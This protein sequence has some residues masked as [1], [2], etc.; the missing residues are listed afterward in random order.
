MI[1][2]TTKTIVNLAATLVSISF[3]LIETDLITST[4]IFNFFANY[5]VTAYALTCILSGVT[6]LMIQQALAKKL[7][8]MK[9]ARLTRKGVVSTSLVAIIIMGLFVPAL[10]VKISNDYNGKYEAYV[11]DVKIDICLADNPIEAVR[12]LKWLEKTN[13][14]AAFTDGLSTLKTITDD[15]LY[16]VLKPVM[17]QDAQLNIEIKTACDK[18]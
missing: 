15:Q 3:L 18:L 1:F 6:T 11:Q 14:M 2:N 16:L 13:R 5:K 12:K 9:N 10:A 8:P 4:M 17:L 7:A